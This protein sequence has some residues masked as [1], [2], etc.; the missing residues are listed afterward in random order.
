MVAA[1][2]GRIYRRKLWRFLQPLDAS[3]AEFADILLDDSLDQQ[4]WVTAILS[5]LYKS[6]T[7]DVLV[8]PYVR[9]GTPLDSVVSHKADRPFLEHDVAFYAH[10]KDEVGWSTYHDSLSKRHQGRYASLRR[11]L[12]QM[13]STQFEIIP[14]GDARCP[15]LIRW[16]LSQKRIWLQ[17]SGKQG[18]WLYSENYQAFLMASLADSEADP[19]CV[20]M[21]LFLNG[22][23]IAVKIA[24]IGKSIIE[25]LI[26]GFDA[27]YAKL[28]P[29]MMLDE[30][31]VKW[32]LEQN[33]DCDFGNGGEDYKRYWSRGNLIPTTKYRIAM[34][35]S[36]RLLLL[37]YAA[38]QHLRSLTL[39]K[40]EI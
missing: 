8:L 37:V 38:R 26:A 16:M 40:K 20:M 5:V 1:F 15:A 3:G 10:L 14:A 9:R 27:Q 23:P 28:S 6:S 32:A 12:A 25:G 17:R 2:A 19:K 36:G 4:S 34:S 7:A 29:G 11:R 22:K 24:A 13:G 35:S 18:P 31:W 33:L 30:H 39:P 21:C